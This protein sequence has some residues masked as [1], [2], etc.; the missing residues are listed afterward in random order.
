MYGWTTQIL[1]QISS[2][3]RFGE[4][5]HSDDLELS[6]TFTHIIIEITIFF[7]VDSSYFHQLGPLGRVG[8]V[9]AKSV[10]YLFVPF[11]CNFFQASHWPSDHMICLRPLIG[12]H[13]LLSVLISAS[14]ERFSVSRMLVFFFFI[15]SPIYTF[16]DQ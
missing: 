1:D 4:N 2:V 14:V 16:Y 10:S 11:P 8:L 12:Q 3:G 15:Y 9:V 5:C 6:C 13:S 7:K